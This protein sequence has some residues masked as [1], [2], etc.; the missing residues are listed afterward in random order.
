MRQLALDLPARAASGRADFLVTPANEA[1][2]AAIEAWRDWPGGRLA[3]VGPASAGKSHLAAVWAAEAGAATVPA[4]ELHAGFAPGLAGRPLVLEDADRA[5]PG[6]AAAER[7]LLHLV[8]ALA[9]AGLPLMLT[10]RDAPARW[11]IR[12]PDLASRLAS[13]PVATLAE[14][15]DRLL[16][17]L[18]VKLF[19]D[20]QL[21]VRPELVRFLVSRMERSACEAERLVAA[22]DAAALGARRSLTIPFARDV[23]GW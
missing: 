16:A 22:L 4:A 9:E 12:L 23:L 15:D 19:H 3:L 10:A 21:A 17:A 20:R 5:L 6:E 13:V 18:L 11:A 7:A 8:N 14:P 2:L 1:A